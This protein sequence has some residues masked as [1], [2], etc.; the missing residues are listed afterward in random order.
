MIRDDRVKDKIDDAAD[1]IAEFTI[2]KI[3]DTSSMTS[4]VKGMFSMFVRN[5]DKGNVEGEEE[6]NEQVLDDNKNESKE[7]DVQLTSN[8]N[9]N[10]T[11]WNGEVKTD[12]SKDDEHE[13]KE[14]NK[15]Q[16][17]IQQITNKWKNNINKSM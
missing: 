7:E 1:A 9:D 3:P 5:E 12:E 17:N 4:A 14:E 10:N 6:Q 13:K 11:R 8:I 2:E 16:V 15:E